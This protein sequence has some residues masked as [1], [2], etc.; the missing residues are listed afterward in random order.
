[1]TEFKNILKN[2]AISFRRNYKAAYY[3]TSNE[4]EYFAEAFEKYIQD[5]ELLKQ[6]CPKTFAFKRIYCLI[7]PFEGL[8]EIK[9]TVFIGYKIKIIGF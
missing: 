9:L 3:Y 5:A 4:K 2:E 1:M 8:I 6:Y 7:V